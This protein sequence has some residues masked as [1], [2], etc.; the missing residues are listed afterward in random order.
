MR[1]EG[2]VIRVAGGVHRTILAGD[3]G[4]DFADVEAVGLEFAGFLEFMGGGGGGDGQLF[5]GACAELFCCFDLWGDE[6]HVAT[7]S[8]LDVAAAELGDFRGDPAFVAGGFEALFAGQ[9]IFLGADPVVDMACEG[10]F[11]GVF[12]FVHHQRSVTVNRV[13]RLKFY[14]V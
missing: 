8:E 11:A 2:F 13:K 1:S 5:A 7:G 4:G 3:R 12:D 14:G 6:G 10:G 9:D